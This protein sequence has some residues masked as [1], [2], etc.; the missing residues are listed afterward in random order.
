MKSS[1]AVTFLFIACC[2]VLLIAQQEKRYKTTTIVEKEYT[3]INTNE[4]TETNNEWIYRGQKIGLSP[5]FYTCIVDT[6]QIIEDNNGIKQA[7]CTKESSTLSG[8]YVTDESDWVWNKTDTAW[9]YKKEKLEA[10][11]RTFTKIAS[12]IIRKTN[13]LESNVERTTITIQENYYIPSSLWTWDVSN[14]C[15]LFENRRTEKFPVY[16][17]SESIKKQFT[18]KE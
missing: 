8:Y 18:E 12:E 7:V 16:E 2:P 17:R 11:P 10:Y 9:Y 3:N 13:C 4:W 15:W 14:K 5:L 1:I 6:I